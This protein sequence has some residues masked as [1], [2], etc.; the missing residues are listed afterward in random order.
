MPW[1]CRPRVG[2]RRATTRGD[3]ETTRRMK[4]TNRKRMDRQAGRSSCGAAGDREEAATNRRDARPKPIE[5]GMSRW[6]ADQAAARDDLG[7]RTLGLNQDRFLVVQLSAEALAHNCNQPID[8]RCPF[9]KS[10]MG[11]LLRR[12]RSAS[13]FTGC[14]SMDCACGE[15]NSRYFLI[16]TRNPHGRD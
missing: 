5:G 16:E 15:R 14:E 6:P 3:V 9:A 2:S 11:L 12:R 8:E 1:K 10:R 13:S 4:V 7:R